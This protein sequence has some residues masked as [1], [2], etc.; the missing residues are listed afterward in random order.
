MDRRKRIALVQFWM[1]VDGI[2]NPLESDPDENEFVVPTQTNW[3]STERNDI[4][5][6]YDTYLSLPELQI[7]E[8]SKTAIKTFLRA[9]RNAL[10]SQYMQARGAILRAQ[11]AT[12]ENMAEEDFPKFKSS[13]LFYK[14][15]ASDDLVPSIPAAPKKTPSFVSPTPPSRTMSPMKEFHRTSSTLETS[16]LN[17]P[18]QDQVMARHSSDEKRP[19]L[20]DD[21][22][23]ID[24]LSNSRQSL[25]DDRADLISPGT[26]VVE[27]MEA[28]LTDIMGSPS[29]LDDESRR[30][31]LQ[32][33]DQS[34]PNIFD[35]DD[36]FDSARSSMDDSS[37]LVRSVSAVGVRGEKRERPSLAALG[38]VS[39][40]A[41][42][43][44]FAGEDLFPDDAHDVSEGEDTKSLPEAEEDEAGQVHEA[45]PGDLGLAEAISELN[46]S[47][48]KLHTQEAI[49][50]SMLRKAE[51]TNNAAELRILNKSKA[52]LQREIRRDEL[53][54]QQ[55]IVQESDNSLYVS[56]SIISE[57]FI[58]NFRRAEHR[59]G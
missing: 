17:P 2:R 45:A 58:I 43:S 6:I 38:L 35:N 37:R 44:V 24:A 40:F 36:L 20:F 57:R 4:A 46:F 42:K 59:S 56:H 39:T 11:T 23:D 10:P 9:G 32:T 14:H 30:P 8:T 31:S 53:Q 7:S 16:R 18:P 29:D 13:D 48:D 28:A 27:A 19:K 1:L 3:S 33:P 34:R 22:W 12:Y 21:D 47:I 55:Y 26:G 52:S 50:N 41:A 51:L 54:R 5:Q 49:I 25:D 15:L